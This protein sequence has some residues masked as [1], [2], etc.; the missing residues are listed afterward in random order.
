MPDLAMPTQVAHRGELTENA[1]SP[2]PSDADVFELNNAGLHSSYPV[3]F[4]TSLPLHQADCEHK[5]KPYKDSNG[6][7]WWPCG[8]AGCRWANLVHVALGQLR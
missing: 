8:Y 2:A 3:H 6:D 7:W 4:S 5:P 1:I